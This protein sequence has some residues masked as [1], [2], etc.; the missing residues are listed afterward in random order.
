[1]KYNTYYLH[2]W[3][4]YPVAQWIKAMEVP[5]WGIMDDVLKPIVQEL[6]DMLPGNGREIQEMP[7]TVEKGTNIDMHSHPDH[8]IIYYVDPG[9]PECAVLIK[10]TETG[11]IERIIPESGMVIYIPPGVAHGVEISMSERPRVSIAVR[12]TA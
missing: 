6:H 4:Q 2:K 9:E 12:K 10:N 1:M 8:T 11:I 5:A 3:C 7:V